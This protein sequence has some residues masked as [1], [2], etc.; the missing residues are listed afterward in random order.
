MINN[1]KYEIT[2]KEN[3]AAIAFNV[4]PQSRIVGV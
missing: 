1:K 4:A 3:F 2:E